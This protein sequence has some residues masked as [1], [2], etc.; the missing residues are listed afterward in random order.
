M[1]CQ[2]NT[3]DKLLERSLLYRGL[4]KEDITI[5]LEFYSSSEKNP[6]NEVKLILPLVKDL[7]INPLRCLAIS[8]SLSELSKLSIYELA[9]IVFLYSDF[10]LTYYS[11][12]NSFKNIN[13]INE[14]ADEVI[15]FI[16]KCRKSKSDLLNSFTKDE[17]KFLNS[18]LYSILDETDKDNE[19]TKD[20][21]KFNETRDLSIEI[22]R[23]TME[24]LAKL[25][26]ERI[27][28]N[29]IIQLQYILKIFEYASSNKF[30]INQINYINNKFAEGNFLYYYDDN[31]IRIAIGGTGRNVYKGK[32]DLIIDLGGDDIYD[33]NFNSLLKSKLNIIKKEFN[34][35]IDLAGNDYYSPIDDFSLAGALF[36]SSFILDKSGDDI[37][38][39]KGTGN[40]G[41]SIG[42]FGLVYDE[43]GNDTY[44]SVI[45]SIGAGCFGV[46]LIIDRNGNDFYIA[47]SYS[48]GFGFTQGAGVIIDNKGND[49]YL[50]DSRSLDIGRYEDHYISMSQGYGLGLRPF[51]AGGIGLIIESEGN[52]IYNT[53]IFGQGGAYWYSFG[54]IIDKY[55][56]DKYNGYQYSQGAG[57][58][59]A[60]GLL[61]D[62]NGWDFY[63][64]NGVSQGCGH[65]YGAGILWDLNGND[66]YSAYS[67]SQGAGN[68][69]GIGI[70]I[71]ESGTDGYLNKYPSNTRGYGNPRREFGSIGVFIDET[72]ND[73]YSNPGYDSTIILNSQWGIFIDNY[74]SEANIQKQ[75]YEFKIP[76]DSISR[77]YSINEYFIMAKTIEPRFSLWQEY[78]F[79][80]LTEDSINTANFIFTKFNT[81]DHRDIQVFR[82]LALKIPI[83]ISEALTNKLKMYINGINVYTQSEINMICYILGETRNPSSKDY[84]LELTSDN[85]FRIRSAAIN[86]LG[87]INY[88]KTDTNFI[89]KVN[90]RLSE[91]ASENADKKIYN[92]DISFS[93]GNFISENSIDLIIEMLSNNYYGARLNASENLKKYNSIEN[94]S[95][96]LGSN[97]AIWKS[98]T[99][100]IAFIQGII[101]LNINQIE[102]IYDKISNSDF[103]NSEAVIYN[104]LN[105]FKYKLQNTENNDEKQWYLDKN[106][107]L[108]TKVLLHIK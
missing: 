43:S 79:R 49:S 67:L 33:M 44:K 38:D 63:Q 73:F 87:K 66:N 71:D 101:N 68:A 84:L 59:L 13:D 89:N 106:K 88:D 27:Y 25:D 95:K 20:I 18:N 77:I 70:L 45:F 48:Q 40:F 83:S 22:S 11:K 62:Y 35:I 102:V 28:E 39:S 86:A 52:D 104:L 41:A 74:E 30:D 42:G 56:H 103:F 15:K 47:N 80:K 10:T 60:I 99:A 85:N 78:G 31:E 16:K 81:T 12:P 54:A 4:T 75:I 3:T 82:V 98:E 90:I 32:F 97:A 96:V 23:K 21:F 100:L 94:L 53:D 64:S 58:H 50:I 36:T 2:N 19:S 91:L 57:I 69:N 9:E 34:C 105:L 107:L 29:S 6:A 55:G 1:F 93:A 17:I 72:G 5:P 65:D 7:M 37:Y 92:K 51:F 108:E 76:V 61:A 26:K 14:L 24:L 46:G 8:D